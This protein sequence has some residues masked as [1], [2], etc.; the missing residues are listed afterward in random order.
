MLA[1][2]PRP[3]CTLAHQPGQG[4]WEQ[5]N[6]YATPRALV[7]YEPVPGAIAWWV[8]PRL[9]EI[10]LGRR[11]SG[12]QKLTMRIRGRR[13]CARALNISEVGR[14]LEADMTAHPEQIFHVKTRACGLTQQW[15]SLCR[16]LPSLAYFPSP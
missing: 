1:G 4:T 3:C 9:A 2:Q 15:L 10:L 7:P 13:V 6:F 11:A 8:P 5:S 12:E 16:T 14:V